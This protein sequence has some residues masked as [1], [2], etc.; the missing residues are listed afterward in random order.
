MEYLIFIIG[1]VLGLFGGKKLTESNWRRN[2]HNPQRIFHAGDFYKVVSVDDR[3]SW[4]L[5]HIHCDFPT[6]D[7]IDG[8]ATKPHQRLR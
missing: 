7:K 5:A 3:K 8:L 1:L 6:G 2:A 4:D